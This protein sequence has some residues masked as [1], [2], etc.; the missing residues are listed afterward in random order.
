MK[1]RKAL[2]FPI[3][4]WYTWAMVILLAFGSLS[5][6]ASM[7]L[8]LN[9]SANDTPAE[10][11]DGRAFVPL[12]WIS[13]QMGYQVDYDGASKKVTV[14]GGLFTHII[15]T[16]MVTMEDGSICN[17]DV[18]SYIKNDRTMVS[19]RLFA[20]A[21]DCTVEWNADDNSVTLTSHFQVIAPIQE[22]PWKTIINSRFGYGCEI[23]EYWDARNES[24]NEDGYT[25][26]TGD[27]RLD[28]RVYGS[29]GPL[30]FGHDEYLDMLA[31]QGYEVFTPQDKQEGW[32]RRADEGTTEMLYVYIEGDIAMS[33]YMAYEANANWFELHPEIQHT[34]QSLALLP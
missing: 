1:S 7:V 11:I 18:A 29:N 22:I 31:E 24:E 3:V 4:L 12:R 21:L 15:G 19:L 9:D 33:L 2:G 8:M 27:E 23:P 17:I 28:L 30:V 10:V 16:S 13:E 26:F 32:Y 20:E 34:A 25:I 14:E 5:M 6:A